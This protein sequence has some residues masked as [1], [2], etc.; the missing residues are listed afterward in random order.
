MVSLGVENES[1]KKRLI[2]KS[3]HL[4]METQTIAYQDYQGKYPRAGYKSYG[5]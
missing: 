5:P 4:Q 1:S 3:S 2:A